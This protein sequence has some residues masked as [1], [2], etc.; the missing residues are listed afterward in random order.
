MGKDKSEKKDKKEKKEK[1]RSETEGVHKPKKEKKEK[2]LQLSES[3]EK[4]ITAQVLEG[5]D[6]AE[7]E[8]IAEVVVNGHME[9]DVTEAKPIGALVPFANPL[10]E[11]KTAKKVFKTV[12][13]GKF[14]FLVLE[15]LSCSRVLL[16]VLHI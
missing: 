8:Q 1:R 12:K 6:S 4:E 2:K 5:L 15:W 16:K 7:K 13:K 10:A 11:D 9:V 14:C 3:A